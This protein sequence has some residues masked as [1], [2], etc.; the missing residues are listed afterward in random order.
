MSKN[1]SNSEPTHDLG[2]IFGFLIL[3]IWLS[4][5][6]IITGLEKYA[7]TTSMDVPVDIDGAANAYGLTASESEKVYGLAHYHGVPEA[8]MDKFQNQPLISSFGL[9]LF[10]ALLGPALILFGVTLLLGV[11][12]RISLFAMGLIYV[13]LTSGLIMIKQ[14]AGIAWLGIHVLMVAFALFHV[15]YNRLAILKKF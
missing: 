9:G 4:V 12:T 15:R 1:T 13:A 5:R 2:S 8:L 7:G 6:A 11:A 3:R 10:D 14:D